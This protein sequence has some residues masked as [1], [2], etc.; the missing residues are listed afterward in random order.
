MSM[1]TPKQILAQLEL[2]SASSLR[3]GQSQLL[4]S[5]VPMSK[6]DAGR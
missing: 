3:Q 6:L 5:Q 2:S 4:S 1:Q